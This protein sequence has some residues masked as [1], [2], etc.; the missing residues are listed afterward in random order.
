MNRFFVYM[1]NAII[2]QATDP[3]VDVTSMMIST[4]ISPVITEVGI[5]PFKGK[6]MHV[7]PYTSMTQ[8]QRD[9]VRDV[10]KG[11]K[12]HSNR[13]TIGIQMGGGCIMQ[14][15]GFK[16]VYML[17]DRVLAALCRA[18]FNSKV[19]RGSVARKNICNVIVQRVSCSIFIQKE[20]L[21]SVGSIIDQL[22]DESNGN[23]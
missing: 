10:V 1:C 18:V 22:I 5:A 6:L 2:G 8:G 21:A 15:N 14:P 16:P 9:F 4:P 3:I 23:Q 13:P 20:I 19:H 11:M 17:A 12:A 7:Y